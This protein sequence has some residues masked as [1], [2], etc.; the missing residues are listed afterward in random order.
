MYTFFK[1]LTRG[2]EVAFHEVSMFKQIVSKLL[3]KK[4]ICS[5]IILSSLMTYSI[6]DPLEGVHAFEWGISKL[7]YKV[8]G[9]KEIKITLHNWSTRKAELKDIEKN[10]IFKKHFNSIL[11]NSILSISTITGGYIFILFLIFSWFNKRGQTHALK[12]HIRGAKLES[13]KEVIKQLKGNKEVSD[14]KLG[15]VPIIKGFETRHFLIH[16][17]TGSGKSQCISQMLDYARRKNQKAVIFDEGGAFIEKFYDSSTDFILNP[18]DNRGVSWNLWNEFK[19][20]F[21]FSSFAESLMPVKQDGADPFWNHAARLLLSKTAYNFKDKK[22]AKMSEMLNWLLSS[23]LDLMEKFLVGTGAEVFTSEKIEK[24]ALSIRAVLASALDSLKYIKE[25]GEPFSIQEWVT[26][27]EKSGFLFVSTTKQTQAILRPLISLWLNIAIKSILSLREDENRRL[28]IILD[29]LPALNKLS[30]LS[31]VFSQGRKFGMC[32]VI[33]IQNYAQL[34][35]IYGKYQADSFVDLCNLK[36][37]FRSTDKSIC[38]WVSAALGECEVEEMNEG[39]SY[40]ANTMR[41][42]VTLNRHRQ[43][44]QIVYPSDLMALRELQAFLALGYGYSTCKINIPF[45]HRDSGHIHFEHRNFE[46][47]DKELFDLFYKRKQEIPADIKAKI[48]DV[49]EHP[50]DRIKNRAEEKKE[51]EKIQK[52]ATFDEMERSM[53]KKGFLWRKKSS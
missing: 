43:I 38:D 27:E 49:Y 11:F 32:G 1:N 18:L 6:S 2:G 31:Y 34:A 14:L 47:S 25:E 51:K 30:D 19:E 15:E 4:V 13:S 37:F 17:S 24:T 33:G 3:N 8:N 29:E 10:L 46:S 23:D 53:Q 20:S 26:N 7:F 22:N 42:G 40:G 36:L 5:I 48:K 41:D 44:K 39:I 28:W 21:D 50:I 9:E 12:K 45:I 52:Q 16:G 35:A